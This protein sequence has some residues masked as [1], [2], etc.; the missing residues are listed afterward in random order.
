MRHG[1]G[2]HSYANGE[3]YVGQFKRDL[4]NGKGTWTHP[5]GD[6]YVG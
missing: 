2:D 5:D 1:M 4:Y 3:R 6:K